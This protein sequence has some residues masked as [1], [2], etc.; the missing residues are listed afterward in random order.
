MN[1]H[2]DEG[3]DC[4]RRLRTL[5]EGAEGL[6]RA[7]WP[8]YAR[9]E[10]PPD[11]ALV[12][13]LLRLLEQT[14]RPGDGDPATPPPAATE[15][16]GEYQAREPP[17]D[18]PT[19]IGKYE[20]I[21]R[22]DVASGQAAAYLAFDPDLARHVVLKR[23]RGGSG[24][25]EEGRALAK[26]DSPFVAR[27]YG[28]EWIDA[29]L[30]LVV[31][32]IPGR[33]LAQV[34]GDGP[35][36]PARVVRIMADL[37]EGVAAVH[38]RGLIHRDIKPANVILHDDGRPRLVDFGVAAHLGSLRIRLV[39]G[40]PP[41]M[42]PEQ[43]RGLGDRID[44]RLDVFGLGGVLYFLLIGRPP[45]K[46]PHL[47]STLKLAEK[48]EITPP[49]RIDPRIPAPIE[50]VCLK[51]PA[52]AP[53]N[54]YGSAPEFARALERAWRLVRLRRRL[55]AIVAAAVV[56][57]VAAAWLW[58]RG[59]PPVPVSSTPS[60]TAEPAKAAALEAGPIEAEIAVTHYKDQGADRPPATVGVVSDQTLRG[61]PPRMK[62]L[63][64]VRVRLSRP[65][66][67]F[68]IALNTDGKDQICLSSS[69][70]IPAGPRRE[71][72]FPED[73]KDYF[74]LTD[75]AGI[76][77]F[78]VVAADDPLPSYEAWKSAVP[79]GLAWAP[80][81]VVGDALWTY[82]GPSTSGASP[83][84]GQ[85][86]GEIVRRRAAPEALTALCDRLGQS[87]GVA[88]VRA[89]AFPVRRDQEIEK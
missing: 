1:V 56:P 36:D 19:F 44:Y 71:L 55:P 35:I 41:Y 81:T 86:R 40:S 14:R 50:A 9:R 51:A 46:A 48:G 80:P 52:A 53:E 68:L 21:R 31:E 49:R 32:Y 75:G 82:D 13:E 30:Y 20:D 2:Q 84:G 70:R 23:Y 69:D 5:V 33:N 73:P 79:D 67:Y 62:D 15:A 28:V 11:P 76:Q 37:A 17:G 42:A 63:V 12:A 10:C 26:V 3:D 74:G 60:V 16:T 54:R 47:G 18:D 87:P 78:V 29:N 38:A 61:D 64:R 66:N 25:A 77:A 57:I 58:P 34:R 22:F 4:S 83:H 59:T 8:V 27:C 88:A 89:V 39:A 85:V 43:V 6:P 45:Y 24:E 65:A 72:E 7:Q